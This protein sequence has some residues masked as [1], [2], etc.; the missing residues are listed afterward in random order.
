MLA[1]TLRQA[2][3]TVWLVTA[4]GKGTAA[5]LE[6]PSDLVDVWTRRTLEPPQPAR[7]LAVAR[8]LRSTLV[9]QSGFEPVI[10][11]LA[12]SNFGAE[13]DVRAPTGLVPGL[14]A[15]FVHHA[16][17]SARPPWSSH[18]ERWLSVCAGEE[19]RLATLLGELLA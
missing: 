9:G 1:S 5:L 17:Q 8:S 4:G 3:L 11:L 6:Q 2:L 13:D 10:L 16:S 12:Q 7:A 18:C 19:S 15:L 14:R